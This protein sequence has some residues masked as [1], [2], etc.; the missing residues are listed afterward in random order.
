[1][2]RKQFTAILMSAIMA[3][4]TC[5]P[6]NSMQ[7]MAAENADAAVTAAAAEAEQSDVEPDASGNTDAGEDTQNTAPEAP[8]P[9]G[10]GDEGGE[11]S[12]I[13]ASVE[14][15]GDNNGTGDEGVTEN[16][17]AE[18][19]E[20]DT[21]AAGEG[22]TEVTEDGSFEAAD[23]GVTDAAAE[24]EA[25]QTSDGL[26][27]DTIEET[28]E[29]TVKKD[30]KK[31]ESPTDEDFANAVDISCGDTWDVVLNSEHPF[32]MYRFT[33][34]QSG[35]YII[36]SSSDDDEDNYVEL[37]DDNY[38][39]IDNNDDSNGRSQF[40][41]NSDLEQGNTYYYRVR[42]YDESSEGSFTVSL[43]RNSLY[44]GD[45]YHHVGCAPGESVTLR[46][47]AT[48]DNPITYSWYDDDR[49]PLNCTDESYTFIP[50]RSA[51]YYCTVQ[52]GDKSVEVSFDVE[53]YN[54]L[55]L[56]GSIDGYEQSDNNY[57][58]V[59][60][61][62]SVSMHA[63][64][65]AIDTSG[66]TYSW[67]KD[68]E[69]LTSAAESSIISDP[70][71]GA[72]NYVFRVTDRFGSR[73]DLHF[74][75]RVENN[76]Q[77]WVKGKE[78]VATDYLFVTEGEPLTLE[79]SAT[80]DDMEGLT[81][82]WTDDFHDYDW[83]HPEKYTGSSYMIESVGIEECYFCNVTDKYGTCKTVAFNVNPVGF[84]NDLRAYILLEDDMGG[85][86]KSHSDSVSISAGESYTLSFNVEADMTDALTYNW[87]YQ[88]N[89]DEEYVELAQ[90]DGPQ[91]TIDNNGDHYKAGNYKGVVH[92]Q[93]GN[94]DSV[95][96][97]VKIDNLLRVYSPDAPSE[98]DVYKEAEL[99][100]S[101]TLQAAVEAEDLSGMTYKWEERVES[102]QYAL[103]TEG[104]VE[105]NTISY[106]IPGVTKK[107]RIRC[108]VT[109][110]YGNSEF[111]NYIVSVKNKWMAYPNGSTADN[112][113]VDLIA[114]PGESLTLK[115]NIKADADADISQ[116]QYEWYTLTY[117][118]EAEI[119]NS[120]EADEGH[121]DRYTIPSVTQRTRVYCDVSDQFGNSESVDFYIKIDS[122]LEA[123]G[124]STP[125][126]EYHDDG[127]RKYLD[128]YVPYG[129]NVTLKANATTSNGN[130]EVSYMWYDQD[131]Y[132]YLDES[133]SE[134]TLTNVTDKHIYRCT[135]VD[136][137][138]NAKHV[139]YYI[140]IQNNFDIHPQSADNGD[141]AYIL[142]EPGTQVTLN[143]IIE[144]DDREDLMIRWFNYDD[145]S[146]IASGTDTVTVDAAKSGYYCWVK[147]KYGNDDI[148][149]FEIMVN[150]GFDA[151]PEGAKLDAHGNR[152][153]SVDI[154]AQ[155]GEALNLNVIAN[156]DNGALTYTW[157][158]RKLI[159]TSQDE[160]E[161]DYS[162]REIDGS[163]SS[164]AITDAK[165]SGYKCIV[166]DEYGNSK[167]VD[168]NIHVGSLLAYPE[169]AAAGSDGTYPDR[170]AIN[171]EE[172]E[173]VTLRVITET[174]EG[175]ELTYEWEVLNDYG[176][177][178]LA[179]GAADSNGSF[180]IT[181]A[182]S[183]NY[184]CTVT[185]QYG[186]NKCILFYVYVD[187]LTLSS[188]Q[189]TP[190]LI[191][192]GV[193]DLDVDVKYGSEIDLQTIAETEHSEDVSYV[194]Y[195]QE[196]N[197]SYYGYTRLYDKDDTLT[198][199]G[200]DYT[201]YRCI[202]IDANG[203]S[204]QIF[205]KMHVDNE[206]TVR[207]EGA[208]EGAD[209]INMQAQEGDDL[210]LKVIVSA[211]DTSYF[212]YKWYDSKGR[213]VGNGKSC[214]VHVTGNS[215]YRCVVK[216]G[217]DN[218][219]TA[220]FRILTSD[221]LISI[222][223]AQITLSE[224]SYVYDGTAKT[225][226]VTVT[227]DGA[228]LAAGTDYTVE[229]L[230]NTVAGTAKVVVRG[231]GSYVGTVEKTFEI[232]KAS[233]T[234]S[235]QNVS[236][237]VGGTAK[238]SVS[239]A[240]TAVSYE[241][242][243]TSVATVAADGTV[244]GKNVGTAVI[245]VTAI[246]NTNYEAASTT[247]S[248]TVTA[249]SLENEDRVTVTLAAT[250][251]TYNGEEHRPGI[252]VKCDGRTLAADVDYVVEF[253]ECTNAGE[254]SVTISG[255]GNY[256]G[257]VIKSY[258]IRKAPQ[259]LS[260]EDMRIG[261]SET[262]QA[263]VT[264]AATSVTYESNNTDAATVTADGTV[265]GTG[266]GSAEITVTA[267]EDSNYELAVTT[268]TVTVDPISLSDTSKVAVSLS[269]TE[270]T[271][272]GSEQKP[273]ITVVCNGKPLTEGED[274]EAAFS[275][276][277]INAGEYSVTVT[278][279]GNYDGSVTENYRIQKAEQVLAVNT[280]SLRMKQGGSAKIVVT[281]A[282]TDI[283]YTSQN[284]SIA[285]VDADGTVTGAG[286]G[287]T[288]ITVAAAG[289]DNYESAAINVNVTVI[290]YTLIDLTQA[291]ITLDQEEFTYDGNAKRPGVTVTV[292]GNELGEGFRVEYVNNTDA[293]EPEVNDGGESGSAAGS[294]AAGADS[295]VSAA[296]A[297]G[298]ESGA[299]SGAGGSVN[300]ESAPKVVVTGDGE[301]ATGVVEIPF[302]IHKAEQKLTISA[303]KV[304]MDAGKT[305]KVTVNGA[306]GETGYSVASTKI[307]KVTGFAASANNAGSYTATLSGVAVGKTTLIVTADG[308]RNHKSAVV[309]SEV[310]VRPK[311]TT[312]FKAEPAANGKGIKLTWAKV[313]GATNYVITCNNKPLKTTKDGKT[314]TFTDVK[315]NTNGAKYTYKI[316]AKAATG[317]SSQSKSVVYYKLNRPAT[318]AATNSASKKMTV[319]WAKNAKANGYQIQYGIKSN[320]SGAKSASVTK[321]SIV[322]KVIGN[323]LKGKI[324]YVRVRSYK[325]VSGK[326]YFSA[327]S[328][329]RKV[330]ISK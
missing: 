102:G 188:N 26:D 252:T 237:E 187:G 176:W 21:G 175:T 310:N 90:T 28:E 275:G 221:D 287:E 67:F 128:V 126:G 42:M 236:V 73:V 106:E 150:N 279:K 292:D 83:E 193:Y 311:A 290:E 72:V 265:T 159:I 25:A 318:P 80:A 259:T 82:K 228:E 288:I 30:A 110:M 291:V 36:T 312:S 262:A 185:D 297:G 215:T 300:M 314:V 129:G 316:V 13:S 103:L 266:A 32:E 143:T 172:G 166:E 130:E 44:V 243:D 251:F 212:E 264:G 95:E 49:E 98:R 161:Y 14:N 299:D 40:E 78:G 50:E 270:F 147:D 92:D 33:P 2:R 87:Y 190:A 303:A 282:Q 4:S 323:L 250:E 93:F 202:V 295:G 10:S 197:G 52:S 59:T 223:D 274:Y 168:F 41:L 9:A 306:I 137:Y 276:E 46:V 60:A 207:P 15:S 48:S 145:G 304:Y 138:K 27:K 77:A 97:F 283:T 257:S 139:Y 24:E 5:M 141:A 293:W 19:T 132:D 255:I 205:Y 217:F 162:Y 329:V 1:M 200:G 278:G 271:Y 134:L 154:T 163:G 45:T 263:V 158:E 240:M 210:V 79:V 116:L 258:T 305:V 234:I 233:Q 241:S 148:V 56:E 104:T 3:V 61:G 227:L 319:K 321:N 261:F 64:V 328:A 298:A 35:Y 219:E 324:Y 309:R 123:F 173:N 142:A 22:S 225:P 70:I 322:S 246:G 122:G 76:L 286:V 11:D 229:Y 65:H 206:L 216:D 178:P 235:A 220:Y 267:A 121:P 135:V 165:T 184:K 199:V 272:N 280:N 268:F 88:G 94:E 89:N 256:T 189:G 244:T 157:L 308:D 201:E 238:I 51:Y 54:D 111:V 320:F 273:V 140:Y 153:T 69:L 75:I 249:V 43:I 152:E 180:A 284:D 192:G 62:Q 160:Y 169:G 289:N 204:A 118:D 170:I 114:I 66:M 55:S 315:A 231:C 294:A 105:G 313:A 63:E 317:T 31:L 100:S 242:G 151:Y 144:A 194:W 281:G 164:L 277:S 16:N 226:Q 84:D 125:E 167:E 115:V 183:N 285:T 307:A 58:Y 85:Y 222:E 269:G 20:G 119:R 99:G 17:S 253:G 232:R 149:Y 174:A 23:E 127:I 131:Q 198:V 330:K 203:N 171:A 195:K 196:Y 247:V 38:N 12:G 136:A 6:M 91:Y 209:S 186:N 254:K 81:Y 211:L 124:S 181:A 57:Y 18:G 239:G 53:I 179:D 230:A 47:N 302:V 107:M 326:F 248:A 260:A 156:A 39:C 109:D 7:A 113:N 155:S 182:E 101:L 117:D 112:N 296:G 86:Y 37:Y 191:R 208:S 34:E 327:W 218:E 120:L 325:K 8:A 96:F 68:G 133:G 301:I 177:E 245:T 146:D 214:P 108:T 29:E 213:L 71:N 224:D 74:Y